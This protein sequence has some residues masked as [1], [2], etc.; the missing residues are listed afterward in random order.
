MFELFIYINICCVAFFVGYVVTQ[1]PSGYLTA[2]IGGEF[3]LLVGMI[4][5]SIFTIVTPFTASITPV[6]FVA[7]AGMGIGEGTAFPAVHNLIS[8]YSK[9]SER[10]ILVTTITSGSYLGSVLALLL[11][12]LLS[13]HW[14]WQSIFYTF[15][16]SGLC[17]MVIY[18]PFI[19]FWRVRAKRLKAAMPT[20]V[21]TIV[22]QSRKQAIVAKLVIL[23]QIFLTPAAWCIF[24][25]QF[26]N[27]YGFYFMLSWLPTVC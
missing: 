20:S 24:V 4:I 26:C 5:W 9:K 19:I 14:G 15:G 2:V 11:C 6:L 7:R 17:F 3:V 21:N 12:P 18:I 23:K 16:V 1:I 10:S 13:A 27:S 8:Q 25:G 22:P